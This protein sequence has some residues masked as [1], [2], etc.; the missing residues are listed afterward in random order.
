MQS[1]A[2][3]L[4]NFRRAQ[5]LPSIIAES[6]KCVPQPTIIVID[7]AIDDPLDVSGYRSWPNFEC[8]RSGKNLGAGHRF[9]IAATLSQQSVLCLD[10]DIFLA[11]GQLEMLIRLHQ[12][13]PGRVHGVWGQTITAKS[14]KVWLQGG[15]REV[16]CDVDI[17]NRVYTLTPS[18]AQKALELASHIGFASWQD[19][20]PTD[21]ILISFAGSQRPRC[22]DLGHIA[23]CPTSNDPEIAVWRRSG[24]HKHRVALI[25][26]LR[27]KLGHVPCE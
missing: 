25:E 20:G 14:G 18:V 19:I 6:N 4:T 24:F 2:I 13:S 3:I 23:E 8:F 16:D 22:H 21:D 26:Q 27:R 12:E 1:T 5:N 15:I 9:Q 10:D 11:T 17:L 7:N